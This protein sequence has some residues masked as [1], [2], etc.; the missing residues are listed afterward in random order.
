[1]PR[2]GGFEDLLQPRLARAEEDEL[3][4]QGQDGIQALGD[5]VDPF[6]RGQAGDHRQDGVLGRSGKPKVRWRSALQTALPAGSSRRSGS[7]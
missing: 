1:V 2:L 3:G 5:E 4:V 6:L 7:R